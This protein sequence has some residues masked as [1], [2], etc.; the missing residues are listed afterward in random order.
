[1]STDVWQKRAAVLTARE[2]RKNMTIS[3]AALWE[4]LRNRRLEGLKFCRQ[5][6]IKVDLNGREVFVVADF[7]CHARS[8]II[9]VDG[10]IHHGRE[11][12]DD[13]RTTALRALG[14][15]VLRFTNAQVLHDLDY[16][17]NAIH[18]SARPFGP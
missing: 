6:P 3:E 7:F 1:M 5:H 13:A 16:V 10:S 2:L 11:Q 12:Q 18:A 15:Q 17:L 8:L 9:E 4:Q 14:L